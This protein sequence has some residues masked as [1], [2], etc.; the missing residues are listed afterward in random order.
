MEG[1]RRQGL[2]NA[3]S[4][5]QEGGSNEISPTYRW[6]LR[7]RAATNSL[8]S[9]RSLGAFN[10]WWPTL[11]T[12]PRAALVAQG[13]A[14]AAGAREPW[15]PGLTT[16]AIGPIK[17]NRPF[18]PLVS[19]FSLLPHLSLLSLKPLRA[20]LALS[21]RKHSISTSESKQEQAGRTSGRTSLPAVHFGL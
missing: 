20:L 19:C 10:S 2:C 14:G 6:S 17:S 4:Y 5:V 3:V 1:E 12:H 8:L 9:W 16:H 13:A 18:N 7:A 15:G 21:K 11:S